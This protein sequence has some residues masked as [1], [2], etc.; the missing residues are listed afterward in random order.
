M[1]NLS[2]VDI[3][4]PVFLEFYKAVSFFYTD[5]I[6]TYNLEHLCFIRLS[7]LDGFRHLSKSRQVFL[8]GSHALAATYYELK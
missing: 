8:W 6:F 3:L 7:V 2:S 5:Y 1:E 4:D